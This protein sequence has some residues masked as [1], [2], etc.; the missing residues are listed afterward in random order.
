MV[1]AI[2]KVADETNMLSLNASIEA[3]KAGAYGLGFS[4]VAREIGRLAVQTALAT[5]DIET[6]VRDMQNAVTAGV[7]EMDKFA[8]D[9]RI[10]VSDVERI[11]G[12]MDTIITKMQS[13]AP[14][15]E[16]LTEGMNSQ[17]A[18]V[19]QISEAMSSLNDGVRQAGALLRQVSD[20][21]SQMREAMVSLEAEISK[22]KLGERR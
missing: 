22:F 9:V 5:S 21:H 15:L 3:E 16:S 8:E 17:T 10:G 19:S 1:V 14:Q 11:I 6:I 18:G 13:I 20:S 7:S 2:S 12:G 4:V